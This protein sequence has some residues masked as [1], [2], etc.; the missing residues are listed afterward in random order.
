M[1]VNADTK[2]CNELN[3][4][5]NQINRLFEQKIDICNQLTLTNPLPIGRI[6]CLCLGT[7]RAPRSSVPFPKSEIR[8]P[9]IRNPS[10]RRRFLTI[11]ELKLFTLCRTSLTAP[12]TSSTSTT[13]Y[14]YATS[15]FFSS[16][17]YSFAVRINA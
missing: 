8:N 12:S 7:S 11:V 9:Q 5:T 1:Q 4:T 14:R 10:H 17:R 6:G 16:F 2:V 3:T 15:G 13:S